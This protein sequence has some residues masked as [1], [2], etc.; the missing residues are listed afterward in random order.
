[1]S[2]FKFNASKLISESLSLNMFGICKIIVLLV[3]NNG[4]GYFPFS[5]Q[6]QNME[7]IRLKS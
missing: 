4:P 7:C 2:K 5:F 6:I 3:T 1:M